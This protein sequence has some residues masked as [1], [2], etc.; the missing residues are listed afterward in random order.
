MGT[1]Q[2]E[3]HPA[4]DRYP[5]GMAA[6]AAHYLSTAPIGARVVA[7]HRIPGGFTDV[8]GYLRSCDGARC[9]IETRRGIV[10]VA[11]ADVVAAKQVPEPPVRRTNHLAAATLPRAAGTSVVQPDHHGRNGTADITLRARLD[12]QHLMQLNAVAFEAES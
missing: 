7:R 3:G 12:R 11:L 8:L 5:A 1:E 2:G 10:V 6:A 9:P 4:A